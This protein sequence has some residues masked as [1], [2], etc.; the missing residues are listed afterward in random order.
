M[1]LTS[2]TELLGSTQ[3]A[4][5]DAVV[6]R[7]CIG[8]SHSEGTLVTS[9]GDCR[10]PRKVSVTILSGLSP[11]GSLVPKQVPG[12]KHREEGGALRALDVWRERHSTL[13]CIMSVC[14]APSH[15][16]PQSLGP[17]LPCQFLSAVVTGD[18]HPC[19]TAEGTGLLIEDLT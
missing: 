3:P 5:K 13:C 6:P 10:W 7:V 14:A 19:F 11:E 9:V 18:H 12:G 15:F 16:P 17:Q 1:L 8:V 4:H 2:D